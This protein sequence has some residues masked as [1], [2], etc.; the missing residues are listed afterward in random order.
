MKLMFDGGS[1]PSLLDFYGHI[2]LGYITV[3]AHAYDRMEI[4]KIGKLSSR[5]VILF[6]LGKTFLLGILMR[7]EQKGK[8]FARRFL[9]VFFI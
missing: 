5:I 2:L 7:A 6:W 8:K 3:A 1:L 4:I 9:S